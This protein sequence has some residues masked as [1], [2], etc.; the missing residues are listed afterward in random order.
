MPVSSAVADARVSVVVPTLNEEA[1]VGGAV[2]RA[3][4][5]IAGCEVLVVDGGSTDATVAVAT[6]AGASVL[7]R[8]GSRADAMNAGAAAAA[9]DALVFLHADTTLPDGAGEAIGSVLTRR[10]GGAFTLAHDRRAPPYRAAAAL[11]RP[12][13]L[14]V[15]GDQ[16]IFV[17]RTA[18]ERIGGY[19]PL[20]IMEDYDLV[21]RLRAGG[22]F[23]V[24]PLRVTSSARRQ[25][26]QGELR[27]LLR[28]GSIKLLYRLGVSPDWLAARYRPAR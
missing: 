14:G 28:V 4:E 23:E 22:S 27:T 10:D 13:H 7:H 17:A 11:C 2:K 21:R 8:P 25:R 24:L 18:F 1:T 3:H 6:R 9:G 15:Y 16:A 5:T 19:A 12:F 26:S 20:P